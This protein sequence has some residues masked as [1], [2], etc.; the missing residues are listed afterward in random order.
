M[1]ID[2]SLPVA[3]IIDQAL[4][5]PYTRLPI[6]QDDPDN[7][8]G[9]IHTKLLM[10]QVYAQKGDV[11]NVDILSLV[12]PP[13]FIPETSNLFDQMHAFRARKEHCALVVDE[14]G[15]LRGMVTLEDILEEIVGQIDDEQDSAHQ[16]NDATREQHAGEFAGVL[17][18]GAS[19]LIDGTTTIRDL[20][21]DMGWK[22]PDEDY[23]TLA[24]LVLYEAQTL[25]EIGQTFSFFGFE[26]EVLARQRH[27]ITQIRVTS[28]PHD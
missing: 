17:R 1:M 23:S 16:Q 18:D 14:Y 20:N 19:F 27:Q 4:A 25:P 5:S 12:T 13:W 8:V 22:L 21:R 2:A 7:V 15:A 3:E 10:R 28:Q 24:G 9:V 11:D 6:Y 26:F